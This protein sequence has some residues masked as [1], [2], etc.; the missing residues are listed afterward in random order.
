MDFIEVE[1]RLRELSENLQK[2]SKRYCNVRMRFG[3]AKHNLY[4]LLAPKQNEHD[5][6]KAALE[7]QLI[8]LLAETP[9]NHKPEVQGYYKNYVRLEQQYKGLEKIIEATAESIRAIQSLIR[10]ERE[11]T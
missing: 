1:Q 9:E 3:R 6:R 5:Y 8:M 7:K 11:Q 10:W 2:N 4:I